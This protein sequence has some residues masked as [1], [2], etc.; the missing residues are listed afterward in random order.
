LE[1]KQDIADIN[2]WN[3]FFDFQSKTL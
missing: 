1:T 3:V 2:S